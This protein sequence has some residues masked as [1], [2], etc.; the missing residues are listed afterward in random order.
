MREKLN[1]A[2]SKNGEKTSINYLTEEEM[3]YFWL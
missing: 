1:N 2:V 3:G